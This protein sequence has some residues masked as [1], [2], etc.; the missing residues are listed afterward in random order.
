MQFAKVDKAKAGMTDLQKK[1]D[2]LSKRLS[3]PK[4]KA[5]TIEIEKKLSAFRISLSKQH[6]TNK[7][8]LPVGVHQTAWVKGAVFLRLLTKKHKM[9]GAVDAET[10]ERAIE[11]TKSKKL[12]VYEA[13]LKELTIAEKR[14]LLREDE[15]KRRID[16][17]L[18][19][20]EI[21]YIIPRSEEMKSFLTSGAQ[22]R[23]L[24]MEQ[25]IEMLEEGEDCV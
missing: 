20:G 13:K 1:Y 5:S 11:L 2:A 18:K 21:T 4:K 12:E 10:Q 25:G 8:E 19:I 22:E 17:E 14:K 24:A 15:L 9:D 23:I 6:K 3:G 16:E 7:A